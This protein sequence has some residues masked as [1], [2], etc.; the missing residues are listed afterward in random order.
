MQILKK[1]KLDQIRIDLREGA[2]SSAF[3]FLFL[4]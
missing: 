1:M 4:K 2:A 3:L